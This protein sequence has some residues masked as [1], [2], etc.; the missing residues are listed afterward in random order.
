MKK[1]VP[2]ARWQS[3]FN[4]NQFLSKSLCTCKWYKK[5]HS[6]LARC[7]TTPPTFPLTHTEKATEP[8]GREH[9]GGNYD[10]PA[11]L[12]T[13]SAGQFSY[14]TMS[15]RSYFRCNLL[16]SIC[17]FFNRTCATLLAADCFLLSLNKAT[18]SATVGGAGLAG[19]SWKEKGRSKKM[20][21]GGML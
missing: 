5:M 11:S 1:Q 13:T 19:N 21:C 9:E 4:F 6:N 16:I 18:W 20:I 15:F 8:E 14:Y 17:F 10:T 7:C 3:K 2:A 12:T